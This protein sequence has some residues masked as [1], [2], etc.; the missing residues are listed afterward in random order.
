M[1]DVPSRGWRSSW[2]V[3]SS[4]GWL[5]ICFAEWSGLSVENG[6]SVII[7]VVRGHYLWRLS[8]GNPNS[9]V[10]HLHDEASMKPT[11][12]K[13][14]VSICARW[15][16][17]I[18]E[19][20]NMRPCCSK[21]IVNLI[22]RHRNRFINNYHELGTWSNAVSSSMWLEFNYFLFTFNNFVKIIV[23]PWSHSWT[24]TCIHR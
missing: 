13:H 16:R 1:K 8:Y 18:S 6:F 22:R 7:F 4:I 12:K 11:Y 3:G 19:G 15:F 23:V 21:E 14:V 9:A 10:P 2:F 17:N 20:S 24:F 5:V